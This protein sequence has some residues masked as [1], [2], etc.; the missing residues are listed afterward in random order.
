MA[1]FAS[2]SGGK[3]CMLALYRYLQQESQD[4][5]FLVNMCDLDGER[6]RSHGLKKGLIKSQSDC[7]GIPVIQQ[8]TSSEAYEVNFKKVISGL[9]N[10]GVHVGIFGDIYLNEHR[11]WVERVCHEMDIIPVFP[12]WK[13]DTR[14]LLQEFIDTGFKALTVSV[15]SDKL[16]QEWLGRSLDN[17]FL[18]DITS[19]EDVDPCA[20]NGEYHTFVYGGPVFRE[21]VEFIKGGISFRD[22]HFFLELSQ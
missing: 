18:T 1:A 4:V 13:N 20:E 19:L 10:Q 12:L 17:S 22:K 15:R 9:R 3:D 11:V 5:E 6:S 16:P 2:W 8:K 7:I 14:Q 21:P